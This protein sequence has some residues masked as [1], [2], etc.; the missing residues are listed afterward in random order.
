[1]RPVRD[2]WIRPCLRKQSRRYSRIRIHTVALPSKCRTLSG[3]L[4]YYCPSGTVQKYA[5]SSAICREWSRVILGGLAGI[6][7]YDFRLVQ[8]RQRLGQNGLYQPPETSLYVEYRGSIVLR[9]SCIKPDR[10]HF[11]LRGMQDDVVGTWC[12]AVVIIVSVH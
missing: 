9:I 11:G 3:L 4:G 1:M 10:A 6:P 12:V 8:T 2:F 7:L 5:D